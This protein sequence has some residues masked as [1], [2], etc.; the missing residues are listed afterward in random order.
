MVLV[1]SERPSRNRKITK[2]KQRFT[3]NEAK[4]PAVKPHKVNLRIVK[5]TR[6]NLVTMNQT[7]NKRRF[8]VILRKLN[9]P[10]KQL[11]SSGNWPRSS[12]VPKAGAP[13]S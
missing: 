1:T 7:V 2:R 6:V 3:I 10:R 13:R 11:V 4:R 5:M 9:R 12:I 8:R